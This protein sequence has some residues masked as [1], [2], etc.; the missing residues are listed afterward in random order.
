MIEF[1]IGTLLYSKFKKGY[2][3]LPILKNW[4]FYL[5]LIG[6]ILCVIF[7]STQYINIAKFLFVI[8]FIP[9][10]YILN[11]KTLHLVI[12]TLCILSAG[13]LNLIA[14]KA[15]NGMAVFP[16]LSYT[17]GLITAEM[18][19]EH[20]YILGNESTKLIPLT[21]VLDSGLGIYSLGDLIILF[22]FSYVLYL[23]IKHCNNY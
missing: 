23:F 22:I 17:T 7:G 11:I 8:S 14:I 16:S 13:L 18:I 3:L 9:I 10:I 20:N 12:G 6:I 21:D 5:P 19:V 2:K 1:I 15:N 4:V